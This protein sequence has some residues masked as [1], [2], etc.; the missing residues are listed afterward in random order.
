MDLVDLLSEF[1]FLGFVRVDGPSIV[2]HQ[3]LSIRIAGCAYLHGAE[4]PGPPARRHY[5]YFAHLLCDPAIISETFHSLLD[6]S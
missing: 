4:C 6:T 3:H 5:S 1:F 2:C